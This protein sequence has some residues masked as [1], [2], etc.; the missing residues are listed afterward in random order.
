MKKAIKSIIN[1]ITTAKQQE[2]LRRTYH[3]YKLLLSAIL[4]KSYYIKL[5]TKIPVNRVGNDYG[6]Q[7]ISSPRLAS[8]RLAS[9]RLASPRLA[10]PRLASPRR[11][12]NCFFLWNRGGYLI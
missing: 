12:P 11:E 1:S 10:S 9:P 6:G 5:Q 2:F 7:S 4:G 3:H 8:P